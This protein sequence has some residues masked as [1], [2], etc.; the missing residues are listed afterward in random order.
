MT[1]RSIP[2]KPL[3]VKI[4]SKL[5][6]LETEKDYSITCETTGSHPRARIT[7]IEG[8]ATF[9]NGKVDNNAFKRDIRDNVCEL[10]IDLDYHDCVYFSFWYA[11]IMESGNA[12]VVLSTLIFS[13]VPDDHGKILKCRG[14]NPALT[15]AYIEDLF[16][17]NVVCKFFQYFL[18]RSQALKVI[19]LKIKNVCH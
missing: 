9:R 19:A 14:E 1:Y 2:V 17:L 16:K 10:L 13:P 7:W 4:L 8:N 5:T 3:T 12:S 11:Q 18:E 6:I 15:D